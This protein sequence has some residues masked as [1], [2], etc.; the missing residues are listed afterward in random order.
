MKKQNIVLLIF[1]LLLVSPIVSFAYTGEII[2][3]FDTP[4]QY[5]T[6]LTYNGKNL[7]LADRKA[8]KLFYINPKNGKVIKTLSSPGYWPMGMAWDGKT[9][10]NV[11]IKGGIP[12][13][14]HYDAKIYQI[15][16]DDNTI[17][18]TI[19]SPS[20]SAR[21]LTFDG[22]YLWTVDNR[23]DMVY[24][25]DPSDGTT[26]KSFKSPSSDPQ[27]ITFDGKCLWISDRGSD[28]IYM[29]DPDNGTVII[30][31]DAPGKFTR[32]L[33]YD[34][35]YLWAADFQ[36]K[37]IYKLRINDDEIM[38]KSKEKKFTLTYTHQT[39]NY[40]P[41]EIKSLDVYLAIPTNRVNQTIE[42]KIKYS[43]KYTDIITDKWRQKTAHYHYENIKS[44]KIKEVEMKVDVNLYDVRYFIYPDKVGSL[45]QIPVNVKNKYLV[46]DIKYQY[47]NP[48]IKN[49][50]KDAVGNEKNPYWIA[51][52]IF[53]YLIPRMYYQM[54]GGWNTAP[55]VLTRGNGSCSEYSFVYISMC[56]AAGIPAR[57][58][59]SIATR[60]DEASM[61][62]VFHR[63]VEIYLPNYGWIPIDP[64]GGDQKSPAAQADFIGHLR[65]HY[66]ITTQG[67][68]GSKTMA[69]TYNS[70][71]KWTCQPKTNVVTE[72]FGDWNLR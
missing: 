26:I 43:K 20:S 66:L 10:W 7:I 64:S 51:R 2:Q 12:L 42:N 25:L 62:D 72:N 37:K 28:K 6:G 53:N 15:N 60:G 71:E 38:H 48:I 63:W 40:G 58:V 65:N 22:K 3:S 69:W 61:D 36:N 27:G 30:I 4:A 16:P 46:D 39:T 55:T 13:A 17:L 54:S 59:G 9:V 11:D 21:G 52:K 34:G 24:Q 57:Y 50:V 5:P 47:K 44:G 49:A 19:Y 67:G 68:G 56:R 1:V 14:E 70:N 33:A 8:D 32:G 45:A 18:R 41:G 31:A 35:K 29:V 23:S